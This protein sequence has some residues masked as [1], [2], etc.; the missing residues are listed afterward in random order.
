MDLRTI[1]QRLENRYYWRGRECVQDFNRMFTNCFL[2]NKPTENIASMAQTL[3][4]IFRTKVFMA[5]V[6]LISWTRIFIKHQLIHISTTA[7]SKTCTCISF[8]ISQ[9]PKQEVELE[10]PASKGPEGA[11]N[12]RGSD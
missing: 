3:Q 2:Y 1:K 9:M 10:L 7:I 6:V 8:Q 4:K 11:R 5:H 12:P